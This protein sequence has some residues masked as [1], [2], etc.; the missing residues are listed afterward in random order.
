MK[1]ELNGKTINIPDEV[2][3]KSMTNLGLDKAGAIELYLFDEGLV[4]NDEA[5]AMTAKAKAVGPITRN[6]AD[7]P[8]RKAPERKPDLLK[9][10]LIEK[11]AASVEIDVEQISAE[12]GKT[13][14]LE[15]TNIERMIAFTIGD[16]KF[17][18]TLTKKRKPKK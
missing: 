1:Y 14:T 13:Y 16:E 7:K 9:R 15:V 5:E 3:N 17:E 8:K 10:E 12:S 11:I 2:I 18:L 4:G 6:Q